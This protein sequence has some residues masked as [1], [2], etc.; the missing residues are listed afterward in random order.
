ML[1]EAV[2]DKSAIIGIVGL[3]YVGLPIALLSIEKG[4]EVIGFEV[5]ERK[6]ETLKSG[7]SY[8][9]EIRDEQVKSVVDAK[10]LRLTNDFS[11]LSICDI[12]LVCVPTPLA[13]DGS[14]N[15]SY[16]YNCMQAIS[17]NLR[18]EQLIIIE[19]TL[20]PET[21]SNDMLPILCKSGLAA[22]KDFYLAY[23]PER[24]DPGNSLYQLQNIPKLVSGYSKKCAELA[25]LFY[26]QLS[27][28]IFS[29]DSTDVAELSK[30]LENTYRDINIAL[31]NEMAQ[32]CHAHSI[33]IWEVIEAAASKPFGFQPFYPGPGV[34]GHCIP[35]DSKFY[36][37]WA[38]KVG[39][40]ASLDDCARR[41]N[42]SMPNY[43]ITRLEELLAKDNKAIEGSAILVLG[44]TYK[45]D[46]NDLRESPTIKILELLFSKGAQ[47]VIH[48]P[49]V[50][51]LY[52]N[53]KLIESIDFN[54]I[55]SAKYD[56]I[57]LAVAHSCY[58]NYKEYNASSVFDLTNTIDKSVNN[59]TVI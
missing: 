12:I 34:G 46:V 4:F 37:I 59:L 16:I 49:Y 47:V 32:I 52:V 6:I 17:S 36:S 13:S 24:I 29:V 8:I 53:G 28:K 5:D 26:S 58:K 9:S 55:N 20:V 14:P 41:I 3:G 19:S 31:I 1:I 51:Q 25:K 40:T 45:P 43:I 22:G 18:K 11:T 15:Y 42:D 57:V 27:I 35:K 50:N 54:S 30:I 23:S 21:T 33:N 48:D 7:V 44:V 56:C 2:K 39:I 10:R 38:K